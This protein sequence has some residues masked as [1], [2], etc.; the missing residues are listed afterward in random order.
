MPMPEEGSITCHPKTE[1]INTILGLIQLSLKG[2]GPN[3]QTTIFGNSV[4][5]NIKCLDMASKQR[6]SQTVCVKSNEA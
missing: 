5:G 6:Q 3:P 1:Q 4:L 2:P